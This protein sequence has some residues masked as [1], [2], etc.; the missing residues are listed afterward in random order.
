MVELK[1]FGLYLTSLNFEIKDDSFRTWP[2]DHVEHPPRIYLP[3]FAFS[4]RRLKAVMAHLKPID[5]GAE[6]DYDNVEFG[7]PMAIFRGSFVIDHWNE[8]PKVR[9]PGRHK[10]R[11]M[12]FTAA[13]GEG[14]NDVGIWK[15]AVRYS[16]SPP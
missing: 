15:S 7:Q 1:D 10:S 4:Y 2:I 3:E 14:W 8:L 11:M 13:F 12:D 6:G 5:E 9:G 16:C